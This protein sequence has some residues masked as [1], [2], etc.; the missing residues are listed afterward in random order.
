[1]S[2]RR[3]VDLSLRLEEAIAAAKLLDAGLIMWSGD[4]QVSKRGERV[5]KRLRAGVKY[6]VETNPTH[7]PRGARERIV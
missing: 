3:R 4:E 2:K 1:M 6:V 7:R 5:L